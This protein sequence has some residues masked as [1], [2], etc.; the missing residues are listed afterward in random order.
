MLGIV[1]EF[2]HISN[3][4]SYLSSFWILDLLQI[5]SDFLSEFFSGGAGIF[6]I[7]SLS[8]FLLDDSGVL[9]DS[10]GSIKVVTSAHNDSDSSNLAEVDGVSARTLR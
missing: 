2:L 8:V 4:F 7:W 10:D 1:F 5:F 9:R 6:L 3:M